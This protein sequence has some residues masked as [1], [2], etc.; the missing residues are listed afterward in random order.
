MTAGSSPQRA[1]HDDRAGRLA[2]WRQSWVLALRLA[3]RDILAH[4][5]R[6]LLFVVLVAAPVLL[7]PGLAIAVSTDEVS[8]R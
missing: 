1:Q 3:R 7:I 6:S 8:T 4:R 5:G 2:R